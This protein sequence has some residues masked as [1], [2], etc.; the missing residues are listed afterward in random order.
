MAIN[1]AL[2]LGVQ[3]LCDHLAALIAE[4]PV[5][6]RAARD[7]PVRH[8][9]ARSEVVQEPADGDHRGEVPRVDS[10]RRL[11]L[12]EMLGEDDDAVRRLQRQLPKRGL[13]R[14]RAHVVPDGDVLEGQQ[15]CLQP[16][17]RRA[18]VGVRGRRQAEVRPEGLLA[19]LQGPRREHVHAAASVQIE[20]QVLQ[21][22]GEV[23]GTTDYANDPRRADRLSQFQ[24]PVD[25]DE[26]LL[27]PHGVL[28]GVRAGV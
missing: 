8:L 1:H 16:S 19:R 26:V 12:G 23:H 4:A 24:L 6:P 22:T 27:R 28:A 9:L 2:A 13:Q 21:E 17:A 11:V 15:I 25:G 18:E 3:E 10:Y 14:C 5:L 7:P 20:V